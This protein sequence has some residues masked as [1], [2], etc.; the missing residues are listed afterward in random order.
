MKSTFRFALS[1]SLMIMG[2]SPAVTSHPV[3]VKIPTVLTEEMM[4]N[5]AV[6]MHSTC[7]LKDR[8]SEMRSAFCFCVSRTV[9]NSVHSLGITTVEEL[10]RRQQE[11]VPGVGDLAVCMKEAF[12]SSIS[13]VGE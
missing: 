3:T 2:C 12:V 1:L 4:L 11:I 13:S 6:S 10:R 9:V 7:M 5:L 8:E